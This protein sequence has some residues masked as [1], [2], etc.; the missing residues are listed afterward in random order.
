MKEPLEI[1]IVFLVPIIMLLPLFFILISK[2]FQMQSFVKAFESGDR[3]QQAKILHEIVS[4]LGSKAIRPLARML[5]QHQ[6]SS[7]RKGAAEALGHIADSRAVPPLILALDDQDNAVRQQAIVA[8]GDIGSSAALDPLISCLH[9]QHK[10]I[11]RRA[12]VALGHLGNTHTIPPLI[13]MLEDQDV[14]IRKSA[15]EALAKI[16]KWNGS[17]HFVK[18]L[19]DPH[20]DVRLVA[21]NALEQKHWKPT[22]SQ[23]QIAFDI[24]KGNWESPFLSSPEAVKELLAMLVDERAENINA[25]MHAALVLGKIREPRALEPLM[26]MF[27]HA[28]ANVRATVVTALGELRDLRAINLFIAALKDKNSDIRMAA[29]IALGGFQDDR[30][31]DALIHALG[32]T[33]PAKLGDRNPEVQKAVAETLGKMPGERVTTA[34]RHALEDDDAIVRFQSAE[35]L[36]QRE[37]TPQNETE[38]I[39]LHLAREEW[40]LLVPFGSQALPQLIVRAK[41]KI[42]D[43]REQAT[44]LLT[45]L[46]TSTKIA[47]FGNLQVDDSRKQITVCNPE[48]VD[49]TVPMKELECIFVHTPTHHFHQVEQFLTYAV[50]YIGQ[51]YLK[52]FVIVHIYGDPEQLHPNLRNSFEN[53]CKQ[54]EIHESS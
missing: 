7:V 6:N 11:R 39:L 19:K 54:V 12:V 30:T 50:N 36:A 16:P 26:K 25:R 40:D 3:K 37:W 34:L 45:T 24:A 42:R 48:V 22:T 47:V 41:D 18:R 53:L 10:G 31:I 13:P 21:A 32:G 17:A 29:A 38:T 5:H 8:L 27:D 20:A 51:E 49:L 28:H 14:V 4:E 44:H 35:V 23:E 15:V 46:L 43:I 33:D 1:I 2:I 52:K 9:E